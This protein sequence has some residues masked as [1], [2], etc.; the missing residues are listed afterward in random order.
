[1]KKIGDKKFGDRHRFQE[2]LEP[3]TNFLDLADEGARRKIV[4]ELDRTFFVEAGAGSGKTKSL[5][6]RMIALLR[7]GKCSVGQLAA[8]T[9]TRK[10]AAE[11]RGRFQIE[12]E[13]AVAG[14]ADPAVKERLRDALRN[15][16]QCTIGTIH[17][18]CAKL[19]RE[20]PIEIGLDP[21]FT[22][23]EEIE[24]DL[25]RARCWQDYLVKVRLE[26]QEVLRG[27]DEAGLDPKDLEDAFD[28]VSLYPEAEIV[29]GRRDIPDYEKYRRKLEKF[30]E[31]AR[32]AVP[33][34]KPAKGFDA[35]QKLVRRCL[36]R[37][38]NLGFD[39]HRVLMETF[40]LLEK[41][42]GVTQNRWPSKEAALAFKDEFDGFRERAVAPAL[43]AW[44]EYRH[45]RII[46][47][48]RPAIDF[49]EARRKEDN[50]L[51]FGDLLMLAAR[52]LRD[53]PEV[54]RYFGRRFT[55]VLVDELQD[56]D[57]IQTEVLM[58]L[59]G[60]DIG[61]RDWQKLRPEAGSLFLVGDPKQ[62]IYRFR[63]ADIDT[64]NCVK[65]IVEAAGGGE[66]NLTTNFRSLRALADWNNPIWK[67][68]FPEKATQHQA[69]FAPIETLRK[70]EDGCA[71]GVFKIVV[72]KVKYNKGADI[73]GADAAMIADWIGWACSG[74]LKIGDRHQFPEKLDPAANFPDSEDT[75]RNPQRTVENKAGRP[76]RTGI[77][78]GVP[79]IRVARPS[80]FLILFR[81][82]KNMDFYARALE[83]RNI[84]F[85]ITGSDAFSES[86]E[87]H[88]ITNL[89]LAL[90]D[91]DNPIYTV[92][93]LRGIFCGASDEDLVEFKREGGRFNFI[94]P[95][96]D[97]VQSQHLGATNVLLGLQRLRKW[98]DWTLRLPASAALH[99]L[100]EESGI[101]NYL[102]SREMGSSRAGNMLKLLEI[103]RNEERK[104][105]TS[106]ARVVKLLEELGEEREI[107]E[108]SLTP[109]R[110]NAVRLMNLHKAK[111][112]EASV[113]FLANP[114]PHREHEVDKH[115][116]R[117]GT[118]P[119]G[120]S[121]KGTPPEKIGDR[122]QF[123]EKLEPATNS[124]VTNFQRGRPRG[125][126]AFYKP[127]TFQ[128]KGP[129][130][131]HPVG[132]EEAAE[133][134]RKYQEAEEQR[135]MYV[136]ATRARD[137]LVISTYGGD[138]KNKP[139]KTLD[140]ALGSV[141]E[142]EVASLGSEFVSDSHCEGGP[143][144]R[145]I[146]DR[147]GAFDASRRRGRNAA[148]PSVARDEKTRP[149]R[150]PS[151]GEDSG[152]GGRQ[153]VAISKTELQRARKAIETSYKTAA[154]PTYQ[155]ETV[156]SL[157]KKE[158][159]MPWRK[160]DAGLGL[161]W[162][163]LVHQILEAVGSGR[164]SLPEIE[165]KPEPV[166]SSPAPSSINGEGDKA[167]LDL[168]IE[169]LLAAEET[170]YSEKERLI[171]HV[172][173]IMESEFWQRIIR[174]KRRY[175]EIP[176]SI[177]TSEQELS[178]EEERKEGG[179]P[180]ILSGTIDLVFWEDAKKES[181]AEGAQASGWV[182]VDYKTDHIRPQLL[183]DDLADL[184]KLYSPQ[185]RLYARFWSQIT[186]EPVKGAGLY[187][188]S[189]DRWIRLTPE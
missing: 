165:R 156:T 139:W 81:Y 69:G 176:F 171:A 74:A 93:V 70:S 1:M 179:L 106:F 68:V 180:V 21:G 108:I 50:Q 158:R 71:S 8:V 51:N 77:M 3:A 141:P 67:E 20:R 23:L 173:S 182:I 56:T 25:F 142:I 58:Y 40:E 32:E 127:G 125:Y 47:F 45:D 62:S 170:D 174:A 128:K 2:K 155:V 13:R 76:L 157:A 162:G 19:L 185:I 163:R 168:F 95:G 146:G 36:V 133:E 117:V 135:L 24:D 144:G 48:L 98:R 41:D 87:I 112:L 130:L 16:E 78:V 6:D 55:H 4:E 90:N 88:E 111:G 63:R 46:R 126:F 44:R 53:N 10:A 114:S 154:E 84:P 59:K 160:R 72:P 124:L 178:G 85:E 137:M 109:A 99:K 136:A 166:P 115:I 42:T 64:Y 43:R 147:H 89:A 57:P 123:Q 132:W 26:G 54:R 183:D 189:I 169:N 187:F 181:G 150:G 97:I 28:A 152:K 159:E 66:L 27:L 61:E 33:R 184:I 22:E 29:G 186:G 104:G 92:A 60:A 9:F 143:K 105:E 38:R 177:R 7:A 120:T 49:F 94:S 188:T 30:L 18:F 175:F 101:L 100:F 113:V 167:N 5:V 118:S 110:E 148:L 161:S 140:D 65:E 31:G 116:I 145:P 122:H 82:K 153:K 79:G 35:L 151:A 164:L 121:S 39:D 14:E 11:L 83:E 107:E 80:D 134:E 172:K 149:P 138:A 17:S 52:L 86:E 129:L 91:P 131:S 96:L 12:L 15:L 75:N 119:K 34:D 102:V 103:V 37:Q 73:A